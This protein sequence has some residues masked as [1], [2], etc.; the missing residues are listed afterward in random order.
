MKKQLL[1]GLLTLAM[2]YAAQAVPI[3]GAI[4]FAG[5]A[6][7]NSSSSATAT[8]VTGWLDQSSA[9]P[10]VQSR[11]QDFATFVGVGDTAAFAA[12]WSF[13]SGPL[14]ALWSVNGFTFDLISSAIVFQGAGS[15]SVTGFGTISGHG[16]TPTAG[17]WRF[18]TQDPAAGTVGNPP[19][20][21]F[22]FSASTG[23]VPDGGT[24]VLLLGVSL[25]G[26]AALRTKMVRA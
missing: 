4:T 19:Q 24:T 14:A 11:S 6:E 16:F 2:G 8:A 10:T 5:G 9:Q 22:S 12:P 13:N 21:V 17:T 18:S 7:L 1:V 3:S 15:V 25:V 26:V 20:S 23:A